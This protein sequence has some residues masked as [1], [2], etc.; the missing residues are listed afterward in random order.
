MSFRI[1][2][3]IFLDYVSRTM[4]GVSCGSSTLK[5]IILFYL[6]IW[7]HQVLV[8]AHGIFCLH[9]GLQDLHCGMQ[10]ISSG[11]WDLVP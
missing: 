7:L 4:I 6:F 10:I 9:C 2:V 5:K 1:S 3:F 8:V 11:M